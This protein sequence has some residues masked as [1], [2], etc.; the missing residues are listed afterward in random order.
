MKFSV[1]HLVSFSLSLLLGA[2]GAWAWK[3]QF[4][5]NSIAQKSSENQSAEISA[6]PPKP[7]FAKSDNVAQLRLLATW[8]PGSASGITLKDEPETILQQ[9][10]QRLSLQRLTQKELLELSLDDSKPKALRTQAFGMA[11]ENDPGGAAVFLCDLPN[12]RWET[13]ALSDATDAWPELLKRN[14]PAALAFIESVLA[15]PDCVRP[16]A[17]LAMLAQDNFP[18]AYARMKNGPVG[19]HGESDFWGTFAMND[20]KGAVLAMQQIKGD[21]GQIFSPWANEDL[22]AALAWMRTQ[23]K[24]VQLDC[25]QDVVNTLT[26]SDPSKVL[27]FLKEF[28]DLK[29]TYALTE[30]MDT[31]YKQGFPAMLEAVNGT[32]SDALKFSAITAVFQDVSTQSGQDLALLVQT[33]FPNG[34]TPDGQAKLSSILDGYSG[35]GNPATIWAKYQALPPG[36]VPEFAKESFNTMASMDPVLASTYWKEL[37]EGEARDQALGSVLWHWAQA[38]DDEGAKFVAQ[39]PAKDQPAAVASWVEARILHDSDGV[40]TWLEKTPLESDVYTNPE[41]ID[42]LLEAN[43]VRTLDTLRNLTS[44]QLASAVENISPPNREAVL[45]AL[46]QSK[47]SAEQRAVLRDPSKP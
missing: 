18:D 8:Q 3:R 40:F 27:P 42:Q 29:E 28:P 31:V 20:I 7:N 5:A 41:M 11:M 17:W 25:A 38:A 43:P 24:A 4:H 36:L 21:M 46:P 1:S 44:E 45:K 33:L 2:G 47:L 13:A 39:L 19:L 32:E 34:L 9:A 12:S 23:S 37:P 35:N 26:Q 22:P 10:M 6:P 16:N 14:R 30:Y 15:R